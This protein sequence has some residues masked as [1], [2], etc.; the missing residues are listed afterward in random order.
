LVGWFLHRAPTRR[1]ATLHTRAAGL[2]TRAFLSAPGDA[3][4]PTDPRRYRRVAAAAAG[5]QPQARL[6]T[7]RRTP[8][9]PGEEMLAHRI[10]V[11]WAGGAPPPVVAGNL[12]SRRAWR[13]RQLARE[14]RGAKPGSRIP[15]MYCESTC[16]G[17]CI[18]P[19][20]AI[21][22]RDDDD[23]RPALRP[24]ARRSAGRRR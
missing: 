11:P 17:A 19:S 2:T 22:P 16:S 14:T 8:T 20:P 1:C 5:Q 6:R 7:R 21:T 3:D 24:P 18:I 9:S 13:E 12:T 15:C 4:R 10:T 23:H